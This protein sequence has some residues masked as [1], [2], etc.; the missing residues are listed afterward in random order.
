MKPER[1]KAGVVG[2]DSGQLVIMDPCYLGLQVGPDDLDYPEDPDYPEH[3]RCLDE[4]STLKVE[5]TAKQLN[6]QMGHPGLA[7]GVAGFGGD[8]TYPVYIEKGEDG[9]VQRVVIEFE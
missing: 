2:V 6:Y 5:G 4:V 9:R 3:E 8:G 1:I 7:V